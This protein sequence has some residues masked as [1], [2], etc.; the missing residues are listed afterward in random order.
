MIGWSKVNERLHD[1]TPEGTNIILYTYFIFSED[2]KKK[3]KKCYV[4]CK[5]IIQA[6]VYLIEHTLLS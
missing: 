5:R 3:K 4:S 1:T 2:M 6:K